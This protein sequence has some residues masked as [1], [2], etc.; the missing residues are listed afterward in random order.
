MC[1]R[2][3]R[4]SVP[5]SGLDETSRQE[6]ANAEV[7]RR[8]KLSVRAAARPLRRY[9]HIRWLLEPVRS[10]IRA[11][12]LTE[13]TAQAAMFWQHKSSKPSALYLNGIQLLTAKR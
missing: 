7:R 1:C 5:R 4:G 11:V 2:E 8:S 13:I 12:A 10:V 3:D 6:G 9:P